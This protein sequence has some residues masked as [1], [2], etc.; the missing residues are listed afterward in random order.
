MPDPRWSSELDGWLA[1]YVDHE[2]EQVAR[3]VKGRGDPA[4]LSLE[5]THELA[6]R[7]ACSVGQVEARALA[8]HVL[9]ERYQRNL[10]TLGWEG[11]LRLLGSSVAVVGAGGLGGW[12]VEGLA[13]MGIGHLVVIDGDSYQVNN[14]NRQLGCTERT[15][16]RPKAEC[17]AERIAEVNSAVQVTAHVAWLTEASGMTLLA[18][19]DVVVDALDNLPARFLLEK[20]AAEMHVPMVHGA[21]GGYMGQVMTIFPGDPGLA[22]FYGTPTYERG[23]ETQLG[24]PAAT[25]MMIAAWE[26]QEVIKILV[27]QGDLVRNRVLVMD[28]EHGDVAEIHLS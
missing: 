14:L 25:P 1:A 12:I 20:L 22:A 15:L 18:G 23:M 26:I 4:M 27:G 7:Y 24:N 10:G 8:R 11:Q 28:A 5:Q 2:A 9:P 17:L 3:P 19:A 21:I 13:R 16:G 6:R